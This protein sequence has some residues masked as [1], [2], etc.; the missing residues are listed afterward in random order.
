MILILYFFIF[1]IYISTYCVIMTTMN[2]IVNPI[3]LQSHSIFSP[4]G[5]K[6]LK[7]YVDYFQTGGTR[8]TTISKSMPPE[9]FQ[10]ATPESATYIYR[11]FLSSGDVMLEY[12][13]DANEE[14]INKVEKGL[15]SVMNNLAARNRIRA[16]NVLRRMYS[17]EGVVTTDT[18]ISVSEA[19]HKIIQDDV[20]EQDGDDNALNLGY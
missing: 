5:I 17:S 14:N 10:A 9:V 16:Y 15:S 4:Q 1:Y 20:H 3:T 2:N 7:E 18:F 11:V 13:K 8:A 19:T 6:L 12:I